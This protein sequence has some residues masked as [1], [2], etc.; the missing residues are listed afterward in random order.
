M[1]SA[2]QHGTDQADDLRTW[3]S[4]AFTDQETCI[5]GLTEFK[6]IPPN[7]QKQM[8]ESMQNA[9]IFTSNSLAIITKM[10]TTIHR[11][12]LQKP[13]KNITRWM[14][15]KLL[16]AGDRKLLEAGDGNLRPNFTVAKDGSGD[17]RTINEAVLDVPKRSNQRFFIYV[18]EGKY[19]EHV[20]VDSDSW[21]LMIY[22][23]GMDKTIVI[24]SLNYADGVSTF[25]SGT[26]SKLIITSF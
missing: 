19:E 11:K 10:S 20:V 17:Y 3:L 22:G 21:N 25:D 5:D 4:T 26:L 18:K 9:T 2:K 15:R 12:I 23:D 6:N 13:K 7:F 24:G 1:S 8:K 16:E 14:H